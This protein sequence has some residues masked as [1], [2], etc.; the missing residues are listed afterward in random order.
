MITVFAVSLRCAVT[1]VHGYCSDAP[2]F[3][4]ICDLGWTGEDCSINC[5]CN[6]HSTC[7]KG[8][9]KC[10]KC[11]DRTEGKFCEKCSSASYGDA[12]SPSG[13]QKCNCNGHGDKELGYCNSTT[14]L[15]FCL[16][17]TIGPKCEKC[18]DGHYG[19]PRNGGECFEECH[20]RKVITNAFKGKFGSPSFSYPSQ[21]CLWLLTV[22]SVIDMKS[23]LGPMQ[24]T[25]SFLQVTIYKD[26]NVPCPHNH[27]YVYD[28]LPNFVASGHPNILLG[29]Y[30]G[31]NLSEPIIATASSGY[32]TIHFKRDKLAHGFNASY[33]RVH[34]NITSSS[35]ELCNSTLSVSANGTSCISASCPNNCSSSNQGKCVKM[36]GICVCTN[37]FGGNDCSIKSSV[38]HL[39]WSTM[40]I[41]QQTIRN[42]SIIHLPSG[43]IGHSLIALKDVHSEHLLLF[44]GYS[45]NFGCLND[46]FI[47]NTSSH[48]WMEIVTDYNPPPR[49][50]HASAA[51]NNSLY[52]Y[53]GLDEHDVLRDFWEF[54]TLNE[55][56][57]QLPEISTSA[58]VLSMAGSTL[59]TVNN[60]RILLIGGFSALYGF[61]EKVMEF[62]IEDREW[63]VIN[64][65]GAQPIGLY[66]HTSVY[67]PNTESIYIFGGIS[68]EIEHV[69]PSSFLYAFHYPSRQWFR[70]PPANKVNN[71]GSPLPRYFH[72]SVVTENYMIIIGGRSSASLEESSQ[73]FAYVFACNLWIP[74][75]DEAIEVIGNWPKP[76]VAAGATVANGDIYFYGG[77]DGQ[78]LKLSLPLD[79]CRLFSA[80]R[81]GC[82]Q[83]TGCAFCSVIENGANQ[84][85]CFSQDQQDQNRCYNPKESATFLQSLSCN[86]ELVE[87]RNCHHFTSCTDCVTSWPFH[88]NAKQVCQWCSNCR[89]GR[90]IPAGSSCDD[91]NDCNIP[92]KVIEEP[93]FCP[94]RVCGA[95]DC[96]KCGALQSCIWTR[97][98]QRSSGFGHT[99]NQKPIF[100]WV[101]VIEEIQAAPSF[102]IDSMPPL[103]CPGSCSQY[104]D[105]ASCLQSQGGEGG[106]HQCFWSEVLQSCMSPTFEL[107][108]CEDGSCGPVL[109]GNESVCPVPCWQHFQASHCLSQA[110]CGW[111]AFSGPV[112]DGRGLCMEG[113]IMGPIGGICRE[114]QVLLL[115]LP[116]PSQTFKWFQL[117]EGPPTWTYLSKP[118]ENECKN[119]HHNCDDA[120]EVCVDTP[121]GFECP[122]KPGYR[123]KGERCTPTCKQG[124][125]NGTCIQPDVC[126]CNFGYVGANCSI[127]CKCNGH[128]HCPGPDSLDLCLECKN[129]TFG[130]HCQKCKPLFVG[131]PVN[132]GSCIS[133]HEY[134]YTHS[135]VCFPS[136]FMNGT[137]NLSFN[138]S[139]IN[140]LLEKLV[141]GP[142]ED[143]VCI[144]CK[145]NTEGRR[146]DQ[147]IS[148][149]FKAG[150]RLEDG[151]RPCECHG[152]G[153]SC[154]PLN[155]ENCNCQNNT[156]TDRQC[157]QKNMKSI[158]H[159]TPCWQLQC[160]KCKDTFLGAP[161]HGHQCYRHM[162]LDREYCFDPD[163][164]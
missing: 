150:E 36:Y 72:S 31:S 22:H 115:G 54:D 159:M 139:Q 96:Q 142:L 94:L 89:T 102:S 33:A 111:C 60:D 67:H 18:K 45:S 120:H 161:S 155:G 35:Q 17:N 92:R 68:Y 85:F 49:H 130:E 145:N 106:W 129:N 8:I 133:C 141:E 93:S 128:S 149:F 65:T 88:K 70:L 156:E 124:C 110:N 103:E 154:N 84:T 3:K 107:L 13:C 82:V 98:A 99:L 147:C 53:G 151:C 132:G 86:K 55:V 16:D 20:P 12:T 138:Q 4:C 78:L 56:W 109:H 14:G 157:S 32:L 75:T 146:C 87:K 90:C 51:C 2:D 38:H 123:M 162:Y 61:F 76:F 46:L 64:S 143:A 73:P 101:C 125:V 153:D 19:N 21:D 62:N 40:Y 29:A 114:N 69:A 30:C 158:M 44:G 63:Y 71:L 97:Q 140:E 59:T 137:A 58:G 104:S 105:C 52:I 135:S 91:E 127:M 28:G 57:I 34:K 83:Q 152:H 26:I 41:Y 100:N 5:G 6:N 50:F 42:D 23:L 15:C 79:I 163:T 122:C 24:S 77:Y 47:Y 11:Q 148:G 112:V 160:S 119:G 117:S 108:K 116:L 25:G 118:P 37:G 144:D 74:L 131:N 136:D 48:L 9:G 27:I 95:S 10:D 126:Q 134:C 39:V 113:G 164:Q 81:V 121:D 1:C 80:N 66:G 7:S 43:R